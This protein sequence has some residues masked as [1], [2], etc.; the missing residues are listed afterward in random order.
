MHHKA[1]SGLRENHRSVH[2]KIF[3]DFCKR[4]KRLDF[5]GSEARPL[6]NNFKRN[7]IVSKALGNFLIG[8]CTT[9]GTAFF[10]AFLELYVEFLFQ[11]QRCRSAAIHEYNVAFGRPISSAIVLTKGHPGFFMRSRKESLRVV[12]VVFLDI[13]V[14][15]PPRF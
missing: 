4:L 6:G 15:F 5:L 10:T 3:L 12:S 9:L 11:S 7:A 2:F 13:K 1:K 14:P 8:L